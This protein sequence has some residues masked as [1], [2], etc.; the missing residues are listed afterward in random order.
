MADLSV[1]GSTD[2]GSGCANAVAA[3]T[4]ETAPHANRQRDVAFTVGGAVMLPRV[5]RQMITQ[6]AV[7]IDIAC[8]SATFAPGAT[9]Q[10]KASAPTRWL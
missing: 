6:A 5:I 8:P 3:S 10:G 1:K 7:A 2:W 4:P 9:R